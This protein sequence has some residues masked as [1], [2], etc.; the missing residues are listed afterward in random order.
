MDKALTDFGMDTPPAGLARPLAA[1]WWLKKGGLV[2]GPQWEKAHE[3]CQM[4]EGD[5]AHDSVHA[6]VHWIEGD[7]FERRLLVSPLRPPEGGEHSC[8]MAGVGG[9]PLG[10]IAHA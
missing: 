2:M 6:L 4:Q 3:L 1:L 10:L 7:E 5:R 9:R 8:G